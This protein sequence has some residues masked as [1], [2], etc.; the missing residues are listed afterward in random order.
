MGS[1]FQFYGDFIMSLLQ[2]SYTNLEFCLPRTALSCIVFAA[3][4]GL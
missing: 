1:T 2:S 4:C 3:L